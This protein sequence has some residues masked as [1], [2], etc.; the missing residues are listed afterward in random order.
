MS[1]EKAEATIDQLLAAIDKELTLSQETRQ[2]LLAELRDHL[3][4]ACDTAVAHGEDEAA[5]VRR[6]AARFGGA[7]IGRALQRVHSQW[8]SAEAILACLIPV[9]AALVLR[10]LLFA[11]DGSLVGWQGVL[12][13]PFFWIVALAVL[14]IPLVQFQRWRYVL[15]NWGFFWAI[16]I[17]FVLLPA[18][19]R[20]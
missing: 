19:A 8:E 16:T 5:A 17:I 9:L 11:P 10:W 13:Q 2:E 14:L 7:E 18:V 20:W 4:D 1:P 12:A 15:I 3:E 6:V